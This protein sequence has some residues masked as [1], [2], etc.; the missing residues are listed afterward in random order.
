MLTDTRGNVSVSPQSIPVVTLAYGEEMPTHN[1]TITR[2]THEGRISSMMLPL[3]RALDRRVQVLRK[4]T[5]KSRLAPEAGLRYDGFF[6]IVVYSLKRVSWEESV[7][8]V[9]IELERCMGQ[10]AMETVVAAPT[11]SML[12]DWDIYLEIKDESV[13]RSIGE[14]GYRESASKERKEERERM[15]WHQ[16]RAEEDARRAEEDRRRAAEEER[17]AEED[18][19]RA[20]EDEKREAQM[21]KAQLELEALEEEERIEEERAAAEKAEAEKAEAV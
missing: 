12:D 13:R 19:R 21:R 3:M 14:E 8:R 16:R 1:P 2:Y 6:N 4:Y 18:A 9:V 10:R 20:V 17:R 5:L 11:P 7:F 15:S